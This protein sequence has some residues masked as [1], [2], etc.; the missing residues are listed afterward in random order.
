MRMIQIEALGNGAH[1][2]QETSGA[3]TPPEGWAAVPEALGALQNFPYG[4]VEVEERD[5]VPTVTRWRSGTAPSPPEPTPAER[6]EAAY[7]TEAWIPWDGDMLTVTQAAQLWQYYAAEG[8]GKADAL[9]ALIAAA[10]AQIRERYP[11][12]EGE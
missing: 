12:P 6:R 3:V 5:G 7:D 11:D 2:N 10:K 4:D 9:Q 8:S 1:R